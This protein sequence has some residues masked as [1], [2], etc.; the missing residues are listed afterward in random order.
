M[1]LYIITSMSNSKENMGDIEL[2]SLDERTVGEIEE[3]VL[4]LHYV[5]CLKIDESGRIYISYYDKR[6]H[7]FV[8][9]KEVMDYARGLVVR[10][11]GDDVYVFT[12]EI[13]QELVTIHGTGEILARSNC[14]VSVDELMLA[15][16]D[17]TDMDYFRNP[18]EKVTP[19]ALSPYF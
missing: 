19:D 8:S 3:I 12:R 16:I 11:Q 13:F 4:D 9:E 7:E 14:G 17:V 6:T 15:D 5:S 18:S 10:Q 2:K 1:H